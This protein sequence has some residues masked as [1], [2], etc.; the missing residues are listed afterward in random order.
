[1]RV[2][3]RRGLDAVAGYI[4]YIGWIDAARTQVRDPGVAEL[5]CRRIDPGALDGGLPTPDAI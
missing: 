5:V 1:V 4:G 2:S 3:R